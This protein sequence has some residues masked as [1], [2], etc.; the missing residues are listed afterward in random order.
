MRVT[1]VAGNVWQ[2]LNSGLVAAG[3][4]GGIAGAAPASRRPADH[5]DVL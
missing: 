4:A 2:A 5:Y 3:G 1:D